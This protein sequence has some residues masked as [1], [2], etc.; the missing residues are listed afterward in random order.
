MRINTLQQIRSKN[1]I[2][3]KSGLF[4]SIKDS[5][6]LQH[7]IRHIRSYGILSAGS[8]HSIKIH[9]GISI[10]SQRIAAFN[11]NIRLSQQPLSSVR[12]LS[13]HSVKFS[14]GSHR[15]SMGQMILGGQNEIVYPSKVQDFGYEITGHV[16]P[17]H[18]LARRNTCAFGTQ[19]TVLVVQT[20]QFYNIQ[21]ETRLGRK[22]DFPLPNNF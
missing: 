16:M 13:Q 15:Q 20:I 14:E 19:F 10:I 2:K 17:K 4:K 5:P 6:I 8:F 11:C 9:L 22:I 7:Y 18:I 1:T 12:K 3:G 21:R